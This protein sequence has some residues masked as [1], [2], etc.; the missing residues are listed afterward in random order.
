MEIIIKTEGAVK[1]YCIYNGLYHNR[2]QN[3]IHIFYSLADENPGLPFLEVE[4]KPM[5]IDNGTPVNVVDST[6]NAVMITVS[7][8]TGAY[9]Q[10]TDQVT[11]ETYTDYNQPLYANVQEEFKIGEYDA[12]IWWAFDKR[13]SV[14]FAIESL[15]EEGMKRRMGMSNTAYQFIIT[16]EWLATL[17]ADHPLKQFPL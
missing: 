11:G 7:K 15:I 1:S 8:P 14:K 10:A 6:G 17:P 2:K 3:F 9:A 16:S 13:N 4:Q 12:V 5:L